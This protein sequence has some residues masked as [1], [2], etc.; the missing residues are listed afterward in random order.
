MHVWKEWTLVLVV[1]LVSMTATTFF[2]SVYVPMRLLSIENLKCKTL[3]PQKYITSFGKEIVGSVN[4]LILQ[5]LHDND[6]STEY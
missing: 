1:V 5:M 4:M 2:Y 3:F 6:R